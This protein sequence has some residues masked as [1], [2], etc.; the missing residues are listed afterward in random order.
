[1]KLTTQNGRVV[2]IPADAKIRFWALL[3]VSPKGENCVEAFIDG[4]P[5]LMPA[6]AEKDLPTDPIHYR[7]AWHKLVDEYA[8]VGYYATKTGAT[9]AAEMLTKARDTG[10]TEFTVPQDTFEKSE[11]EKLEDFAEEH[12][13]IL[14]SINELG[15]KPEDT[16]RNRRIWRD[17]DTFER[18]NIIVA[19]ENGSYE[20]SLAKWRALQRISA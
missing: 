10:A 13:L 8:T 17:T 12:G 7:A 5:A 19:D 11:A 1:M 2:E 14:V 20:A 3:S 9:Q 15:Y 6:D 4:K 18:Q 16:R